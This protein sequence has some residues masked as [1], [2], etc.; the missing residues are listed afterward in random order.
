MRVSSFIVVVAVSASL[1][2]S[3]CAKKKPQTTPPP[4]A[5]A[6]VEK[7]APPPPPPPAPEKPPAPAVDP[8]D[9]DIASVN[10][11]VRQHGLI[12]DVYYDY[13]QSALRDDARA[14]LQANA[15][16]MKAHPQFLFSL[17]GHC[18]E[19]GSVG[20]NVALG[21][22]RANSAKSYIAS[23]GVADG[24]MTTVSYGKERPFCT[25]SNEACWKQNRR[26]H[27]VITGRK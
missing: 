27:F 11:Y 12:D 9:G 15:D 2:L 16:F 17:E 14:R 19:R 10:A 25:E 22:R 6:P 3:G 24:I 26:T 8:L 4:P 1:V 23:L 7:P 21:D 5:Q 20:Y 18:D 13:D